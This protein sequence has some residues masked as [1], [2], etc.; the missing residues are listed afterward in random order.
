[1]RII[2]NLCGDLSEKLF[3]LLKLYNSRLT[4]LI[5]GAG[6]IQLG[7]LNNIT[8]KHLCLS[9]E[10]VSLFIL[11]IPCIVSQVKISVQGEVQ[12]YLLNLAENLKKDMNNHKQELEK[13]LASILSER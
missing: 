6:A 7:N 5:L 11:Q 8:A 12:K 10:A 9:V 3:Q 1:M 2:E 13:K 4:Q